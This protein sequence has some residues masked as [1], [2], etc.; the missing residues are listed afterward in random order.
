MVAFV[1]IFLLQ[2]QLF[3]LIA[4]QSQSSSVFSYAVKIPLA[5]SRAPEKLPK[6]EVAL[7]EA[8]PSLQHPGS[9]E[10]RRASR[11]RRDKT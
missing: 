8:K 1:F 6:R 3:F 9:F 11:L 2:R 7:F 4:K 10:E 5:R